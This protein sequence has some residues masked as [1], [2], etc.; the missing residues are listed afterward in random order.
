MTKDKKGVVLHACFGAPEL[1]AVRPIRPS[2]EDRFVSTQVDQFSTQLMGENQAWRR[3]ILAT[4]D[5][6]N[7]VSL[8]VL[9]K[10]GI[11]KQ[12]TELDPDSGDAMLK[13]WLFTTPPY[14]WTCPGKNPC[15]R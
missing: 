7:A 11:S 4:L 5:F 8:R 3:T 13:F 6:C 12:Q 2:D 14:F 15:R 10:W 1:R 9:N